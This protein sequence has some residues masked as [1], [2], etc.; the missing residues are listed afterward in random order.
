MML[1][2]LYN[3]IEYGNNYSKILKVLWLFYRDE[4]A[5]NDTGG[6]VNFDDN[7]TFKEKITGLTDSSGLFE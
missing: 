3:L 1:K 4:L 6:I 5:L 2:A 7:N